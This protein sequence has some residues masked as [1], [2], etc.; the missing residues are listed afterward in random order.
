MGAAKEKLPLFQIDLT[1]GEEK[2]AAYSTTPN[3]VVS[4]ILSIFDA[5]VKSLQEINQVEHKLLPNLFKSNEKQYLK[6]TV[7]PD[8]RP[9][10]PDPDNKRELPD[11]NTWV[12]DEYDKLRDCVTKI[13]DPLE[14]YCKT[15]ERF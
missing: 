6:A 4:L 1:V 10:E 14:A 15:Y 9:E 2:K 3:E 13:I 7:R 8:Y 11:P 5:G 12:F